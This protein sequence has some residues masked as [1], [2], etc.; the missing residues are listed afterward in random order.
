MNTDMLTGLFLNLNTFSTILSILFQSYMFDLILG[1]IIP[2]I[3]NSTARS[4]NEIWLIKRE[5]NRKN[6][7]KME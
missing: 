2:F 5:E 6:N 4:H 7:S 1:S 3:S